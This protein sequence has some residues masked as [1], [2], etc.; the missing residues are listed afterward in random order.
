ME[1]ATVIIDNGTGYSKMGYAG[2]LEPSFILPSVVA[3]KA[4]PKESQGLMAQRGITG[5]AGAINPALDFFI[6]DE[7]LIQ[8]P[9]K[10][11]QSRLVK[12]GQIS[13]WEGMEMFWQKSMH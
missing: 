6:G 10:Y 7:A 3:K 13:D 9:Q 8:S 12:H 5:G 2:N 4:T 1:K 11:D